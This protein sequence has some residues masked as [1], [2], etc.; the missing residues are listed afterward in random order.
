M[1]PTVDLS[2]LMSDSVS[3]PCTAEILS[4]SVSVGMG[5]CMD[6]SDFGDSL[7]DE[8]IN[9]GLSAHLVATVCI[10]LLN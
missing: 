1:F 7:S 3:C 9:R 10:S 6:M 5:D 2:T 8:T 4:S